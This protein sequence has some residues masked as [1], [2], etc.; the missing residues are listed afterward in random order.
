MKSFLRILLTEFSKNLFNPHCTNTLL[1][2]VFFSRN[3][4]Y[5]K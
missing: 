3:F 4:H 5:I 1:A 2:E